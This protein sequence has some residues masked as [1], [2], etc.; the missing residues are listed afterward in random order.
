[1]PLWNQATYGT[2]EVYIYVLVI[3]EGDRGYANSCIWHA[4]NKQANYLVVWSSSLRWRRVGPAAAA[5]GVCVAAGTV[6]QSSTGVAAP[7]NAPSAGAVVGAAVA[8]QEEEEN[9]GGDIDVHE[10]KLANG[11]QVCA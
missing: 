5:A 2:E 7:P 11:L 4:G 9:D 1:M 6:G 10:M 3:V 8:A